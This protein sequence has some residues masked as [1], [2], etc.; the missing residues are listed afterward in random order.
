MFCLTLPRTLTLLGIALCSMVG[1]A[2]GDEP[3]VTPPIAPAPPARPYIWEPIG[4]VDSSIVEEISGVVA[5]RRHPGV[6]WVH[7][8]SGHPPKLVAIDSNG[9]RLAEVILAGAPNIDW[10]DIAIDDVGRLYIGDIGNNTG[11]LPVR[12]VYTVEEPDPFDPPQAPV[13][14]VQ[15]WRV[16]Y[17]EGDRV[18][19]EGLFWHAGSLYV[20]SR[21]PR[22]TVY[23]L[24]PRGEDELV[25]TPVAASPLAGVTGADV[26][27]DGHS[28]LLCSS[29]SARLFNLTDSDELID[30]RDRRLITY[31]GGG[32]VEACCFSGD[33][34]TL[35]QEDGRVFRV[36]LAH[37]DEQARYRK[38]G[39]GDR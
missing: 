26:S 10:E 1:H 29:A 34:V 8:D 31:P 32:A 16:R 9:A 12:Y 36:P 39:R 13:R 17:A 15:H 6:Y 2:L 37:F 19:C 28:L 27:P 35:I 5:S 3:P 33:Q 4:T 22:S 30:A 38:R 21:G 7:P 24:V 18:N 14:P 20:V 25:M 23:R 11:L